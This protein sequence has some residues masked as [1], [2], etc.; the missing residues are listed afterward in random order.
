MIPFL[1]LKDI[2]AQYDYEL[3]VAAARVIDSG[4]YILGQ[5]VREFEKA[6]SEYC[7]VKHCIGVSNGLDALKL[8]LKAY[9]YGTGDEIIVQSNTY[10]ASILAISEVGATPVLVE[11]DI[12]TYNIS[13]VGIEKSITENTKAILVVHL[14]GKSAEMD[15]IQKIANRYQIKII[16][17]AA[18]AHGAIYK[19]KKAGNLGDAA[20]FSFYPGKNLGALG[21]A[22]AITTNDSKLANK[23][24][25]LRNYGS[26]K[27]YENQYK[28]YNHRLDEMQAAFLLVKLKYLDYEN[29]ERRGIA[30]KYL[31]SID[32]PLIK[33]PSI[34]KHMLENVWHLFV[35]RTVERDRLQSYLSDQGIQTLIHYPLPPHRQEAYFEMDNNK[36]EISEQIHKE[37]L[38]LPISSVQSKEDTTKII[39]AINNFR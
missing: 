37:V 24:I 25:A 12:H 9:G 33:L 26:H 2:N 31:N 20:G 18:Q 29:E 35:I 21:D 6:F 28:G 5:E 8:I 7:G 38:S 34:S 10:I 23:I 16:E 3:K 4:W 14:Y 36:Y 1:N 27:K 30:K 13:P 32:N 22:G 15:E 11:P 19:G 17:D 39:E